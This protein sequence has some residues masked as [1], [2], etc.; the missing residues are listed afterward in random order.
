MKSIL[1]II[2]VL[3]MGV[4]SIS[5]SF[6]E[7]CK[8]APADRF[9]PIGKMPLGR[10]KD[11]CLKTETKRHLYVP[12]QEEL[13]SI[14]YATTEV[15]GTKTVANISHDGGFVIADIPIDKITRILF[16][17]ERFDPKF[18]AAHTQLRFDFS[19]PFLLKSQVQPFNSVG[20]TRSLVFSTEAIFLRSGPGYDLIKGT[21][22]FFGLVYRLATTQQKYNDQVIKSKNS[23]V[24]YFLNLSP[25]SAQKLFKQLLK[26]YSGMEVTEMYNTLTRN[27]T[28]VL[29]ENL[30]L[31]NH[32]KSPPL[33][34]FLA[35]IP[36]FSPK[37]LYKRGLISKK[38]PNMVNLENDL[39]FQ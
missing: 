21:N 37:E 8:I 4:L 12:S 18:I 33:Q 23:V 1:I 13:D 25:D 36:V 31:M 22:N 34:S 39:S 38:S 3:A 29:F 11:Q 24:Q 30:D 16:Q 19:E 7:D 15:L 28:N 32:R 10:F 5:D 6:A 9:E 17:V 14:G 26:N 20:T 2:A 35:S 27:C